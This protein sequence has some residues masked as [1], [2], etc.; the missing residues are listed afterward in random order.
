MELRHGQPN[1]TWIIRWNGMDHRKQ[2]WEALWSDDEWQAIWDEHP[3]FEDYLHMS[4]RF[5]RQA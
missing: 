4:I 2:G 3:G 1:V 5:L